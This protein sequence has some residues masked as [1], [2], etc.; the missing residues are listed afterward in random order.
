MERVSFVP[1]TDHYDNR[2]ESV[3]EQICQLIKKRKELSDNNPGFPTKQHIEE[4]AKKYHFYEDF[5]NSTFSGFLFEELYKPVVEPKGFVGNLPI[6]QS[7]EKDGNFYSVTFVRQY[8]NASIVHLHV[9]CVPM[10]EQERPY[11]DLSIRG[12]D[13]MHYDCR[14]QGGGGG[15]GHETTTF[16]VSPALP[17]DKETYEFVFT[18]TKAPFQKGAGEEFVI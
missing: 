4:W 15:M 5:L 2:I 16:L 3:D 14:N 7:F 9:D 11:F 6:L 17:N 1:P 10:D 18:E 12:K 8:E 13:G